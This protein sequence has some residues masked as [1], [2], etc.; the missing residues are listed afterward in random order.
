MDRRH[1]HGFGAM[2]AQIREPGSVRESSRS[3]SAES[4]IRVSQPG[5]SRTINLP[6]A[7]SYAM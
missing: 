2:K 6:M 7:L 1:G 4:L 3:L 5:Y